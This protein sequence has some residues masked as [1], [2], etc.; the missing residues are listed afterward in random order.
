M[1]ESLRMQLHIY[2][3][4]KGHP[5]QVT[6]LPVCDTGTP[7]NNILHIYYECFSAVF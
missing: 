2:F 4:V 7:P 1:E 3:D 6:S 5:H